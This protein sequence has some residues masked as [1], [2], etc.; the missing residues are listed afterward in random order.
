MTT[1]TAAPC[2]LCR[3][4]TGAIYH[5]TGRAI[6]KR[7][8]CAMCYERERL[9][10]RLDRWALVEHALPLAHVCPTCDMVFYDAAYRVRK[11][12][13]WTCANRPR[14]ATFP[15]PAVVTPAML[16]ITPGEI[17]ERRLAAEVLLTDAEAGGLTSGW[18]W[19]QRHPEQF[20]PDHLARIF[21]GDA[22]HA[23]WREDAAA[24]A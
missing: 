12:C 5:E 17:E 15:L 9:A 23:F 16:G 14:H 11:F 18:L 13:S 19:R 3:T 24:A 7:G 10:G 6:R 8:L 20:A 1:T 22:T 4:S 21:G 2:A